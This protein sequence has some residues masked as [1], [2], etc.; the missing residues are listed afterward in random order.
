MVSRDMK[1]LV[2]LLERLYDARLPIIELESAFAGQVLVETQFLVQWT[3]VL[4]NG[5]PQYSQG[6]I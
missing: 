5:R 6:L 4:T 2:E 3:K 1:S